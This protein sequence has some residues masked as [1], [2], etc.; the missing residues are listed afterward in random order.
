MGFLFAG[1]MIPVED[2]V[3]PIRIFCYILPLFYGFRS[4]LYLEMNDSTFGG[5]EECFATDADCSFHTN[6]AGE[7]IIP[8]WK[9]TGA[10]A[11]SFICLGASGTQVLDSLGKNYESIGS[12]D[13]VVEDALISLGIG[14]V[15]KLCYVVMINIKVKQASVIFPP[16]NSSTVKKVCEE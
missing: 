12:E 4:T 6:D 3:W 1:I 16:A 9:C 14:L 5:A 8:G 11:D 10:G 7:N 15:I 13:T 2:V